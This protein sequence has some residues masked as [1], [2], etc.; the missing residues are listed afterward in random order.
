[1]RMFTCLVA[2]I[3]S[4]T[5][6]CDLIQISLVMGSPITN[7]VSGKN[8]QGE[9]ASGLLGWGSGRLILRGTVD[10]PWFW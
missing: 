6:D 3:N 4:P 2:C 5:V 7:V 1:M 9:G 8:R 10:C